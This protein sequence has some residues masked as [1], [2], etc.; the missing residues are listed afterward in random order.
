MRNAE[1]VSPPSGASARSAIA[2]QEFH[3][4]N[5]FRIGAEGRGKNTRKEQL[6]YFHIAMGSTR[7]AQAALILADLEASPAWQ[8]LDNLAASL[9]R[10]ILHA[11]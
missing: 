5:P 1:R 9:Y 6:R 8:Q 2:G 3:R 11:R 10:L 7:E 4:A